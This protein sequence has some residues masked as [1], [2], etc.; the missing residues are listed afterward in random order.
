VPPNAVA[1]TASGKQKPSINCFPSFQAAG[2][3]QIGAMTASKQCHLLLANCWKDRAVQ[4][5]SGA[6]VEGKAHCNDSKESLLCNH[7]CLQCPA[8]SRQQQLL[9]LDCCS[10]LLLSASCTYT[11]IF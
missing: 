4:M 7:A 10:L 2:T 9:L 8:D 3:Q 11:K 5:G 6:R 1:I